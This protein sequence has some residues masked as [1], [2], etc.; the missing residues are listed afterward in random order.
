M[1]DTEVHRVP[2]FL[3]GDTQCIRCGKTLHLYFNG[4]EL[5]SRTCCGLE[6]AQESRG[7]DLVVRDPSLAKTGTEGGAKPCS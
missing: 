5:D 2:D 4:G 6:Y 1:A 3:S 7:Y